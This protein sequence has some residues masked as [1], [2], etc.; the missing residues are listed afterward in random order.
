MF[1]FLYPE[2]M[3]KIRIVV[4][5]KLRESMVDALYNMNILDLR[6]SHL[7][8]PID[9]PPEHY[10]EIRDLHSKISRLVEIL[11]RKKVLKESR[12]SIE[13]LMSNASK[14]L[15][16]L[17]DLQGLYEEENGFEKE[18]ESTDY[19]KARARL[20]RQIIGDTK[21]LNRISE[22]HYSRLAN[23]QR[24]LRVELD[25]ES[26][27]AFIKK[28]DK[29]A[30]IEGWVPKKSVNKLRA[31]LEKETS[32]LSTVESIGT[33]ELPPTYI[34]S[35]G[36]MK[37]FDY[38]VNL[39]SA[40]RSDELNPA[41]FLMFS[42]PILYGLMV[43]DVGYGILSLAISV[44]I[45]KIT[46]E[47]SLYHNLANIWLLSSI[48]TIFFGILNNQYF[49][50]QLDH[51]IFP[52][53]NGFDWSHNMLTV[54]AISI[55]VGIFEISVGLFLGM[56]NAYNHK[57]TRLILF[58]LFLLSSLITGTLL[59]CGFFGIVGTSF[60]N[61][62]A[63]ALAVSVIGMVLSRP[64]SSGRILDLVTYPLSYVRLMGFGIASIIIAS[65]IDNAF[66]PN[67]SSGIVVFSVYI[68][69]YVVL[70]LLNMA[71]ST[72]EAGIQSMR[73]NFI[74][75]F[76]QFYTGKGVKYNPFGYEQG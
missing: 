9:T 54:V 70:H 4:P 28:T 36:I 38:V 47:K 65:I 59:A 74:E 21:K 23:L 42:F 11:P 58:K 15:E 41:W 64:S 67:P 32:G 72:F 17:K 8:L 51:Y 3:E 55:L 73:L 45:I 71:L 1:G 34:K 18:R 53:F 61:P 68:A 26:A 75:F 14:E 66:T 60:V 44:L 7:D 35:T 63:L 33:V 12:L 46:E 13:E 19:I 10:E 56:V 37:S 69:V 20:E 62:C 52:S 2:P 30:V 40:P 49:G 48:F 50:M 29:T 16:G 31:E 43:S 24:M 22:R 57:D 76:D 39:F 6:N 25:K 5:Y 27:Y